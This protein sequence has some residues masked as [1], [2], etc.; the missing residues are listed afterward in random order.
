[1]ETHSMEVSIERT[2][3]ADFVWIRANEHERNDL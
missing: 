1:M 2:F 3:F